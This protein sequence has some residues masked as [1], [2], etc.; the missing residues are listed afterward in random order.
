MAPE[1]GAAPRA[2]CPLPWA[3]LLLL[4]ALLPV[5]SPAGAPA[6]HPLKPR[7]VKLLSTKMGLKVTWDPPK[8]ATSRP[9]EHYNIAYG[10]S[11]KSLKYIKV[12]AE[13]HSFLI[14]DVEPGVVY[15]VLVTAENHNGVSRPVYRAESPPGGEWIQIDGFPIKGPGPFNETV[16]EKEVPNKPLRVRVRSSDDR[17]SIAWKA[18]R[19]SGAKSPRRS[20]GFLLGYGESGR[21]MNYVPLTR[22]ER[23]HEIKKLASESVYVVSLQSMNSQGQSQPVYRA[24]LTKRKISEEDELDV[25]E[26]INVRVMS[27]QSVLVAWVDPVLEKQKKVVASRQYTVRYREKGELARWDHKQTSNRRVL[28]ENLI[29]DTMYEFA[30]RISQGERDGKWSTSVFQRTPESAPTTAPENLN[31]WPVSGKPTAVTVAWDALPETEGKV[32]EYILSY[33]PALK[34]FGAKSLTYPG[35]TTSALV[36]G[37]QPGERYL[38]KIRAANRRGLGPHSKAFIVAIPTTSSSESDVQQKTHPEDNW[39]SEKPETSPKAPTS[40]KHTRLPVSPR[41][42]NVK[43]PL[44]DLKNKILANSGVPRK[45]QIHPKKTEGLDLQSTEIT[46]EEERDSLGDPPTLPSETQDQK[47]QQ[48]LPSRSVPSVLAP[49]RTPVRVQTPGLP[50]KEGID[51]G[52]SS[53]ASYPRPG[54]SPSAP[55][56]SVPHIRM[57]GSPRRPSAGPSTNLPPSSTDND[58]VGQ[59]EE[60]P[61]AGSRDPKDAA[62]QRLPPKSTSHAR[63]ALWPSGQAT[64][65]ALRD[66]SPVHHGTKPALPARR[67]PHLGDREDNSG[68][69]VPP[70]RLSPPQGGSSRLPPTEPHRGA[71]LSRGWKDGYGAAA[72]KSN[73]PSQSRSSSSSGL[74]S[75]TQGSEGE[76]ASD[77]D[78]DNDTEDRGRQAEATAP[79]SRARLPAG[80]PVS[81]HFNLFRN[82]PFAAHT[83]Y[84]SRFGS[85]RGPRLHPSSSPPSTVSPRVH[86]RVNS[87]EVAAESEAE[88]EKPLPATVGNDHVSSS[89]RQPASLAVDHLRK[90]PQRGASL[91]Q[92]EPLAENPK[93]ARP[94]AGAHPQGKPLPSK[95]LDV[96]QSTEV[97][98][99]GGYPKAHLA[100][101]R[102]PATR[103]QH[104]PRPGVPKRTAPGQGL[105]AGAAA[106]EG[107]PSPAVSASQ[108]QPR[109]PQSKDVGHPLSKPKPEL[110]Q[111]ARPHPRAQDSASFSD[112]YA[113]RGS[114]SPHAASSRGVLPTS[115]HSQD[116]DPEARSVGKH[117]D[118]AEAEARGAREPAHPART[119]DPTLSL[120]KHRQPEAPAGGAG[121]SHL[122]RPPG[123]L[124][125]PGG[126]RP[127]PLARPRVPGRAGP[128]AAGKSERASQGAPSKKE[129][130][131]AKSQQSVSAEEEGEGTMFFKGGKDGDPLS[132][133]VPKWPSSSPR[134][135]KY[136]DGN[137]AKDKTDPA[138]VLAP[139]RVSPPQEEK[140]APPPPPGSSPRAPLAPP[141]HPHRGPATPS[142]TVG[143]PARVRY[144]T[145]APPVLAST[146]PMLSLRQ[147]MMNSRFRN[148]LSRQPARSPTRQGYNGSPNVEG[149]VLPGSNGKPSGQ[150]IING[151]QGTKW[152]VDLDRGLVLNAE[153][154]YLQDS[155][156]N[157]LR[158]KLGGDG[159]TIVD[160]GGTPVVSPDGLPL[161]GQGRH[162]K[163]LA[164][165]QD[166]PIL[167]L[168]GKP[169]VGLEVV[170]TTTHAPITTTRPT[171][172]TLR[173]TTATTSRMTTTTRPTT[174]IRTTTQTTTTTTT[175]T[176]TPEPTTP[177]PTCPP[178]TLERHDEDGNLITGSSG[179]PECYPEEDDFSGLETDTAMPT[180]EAYV[181]YDEDYEFETSRPPTTTRPS[182]TATVPEVI[183]VEGS[184]SSFPGEEFDLAGKKR[185]VAPYVTYLSKDP[186]AP[187]S[188]TDALDHFQVDSLDEIIPNDMR[189]SDLAPQHPPRNI[190]V[191]AV[192]GCHSFVIVDWD[193]ATPG[194]V[195]TGYLVY[196]ASYEDFIR[197]KWST[198]ASSVTHLP[199]ENLKPNTR[200]YFKVQAK[201][202]HGYGPISPSVSFV[203]E[204]DNP[205]LVVRPPGGEPIW[206]PFT[207]KHDPSYTDCHG[208]QYVK[209]TWY[210]KFVGVVLCNSLRYKI[211]LSDNLKDTFYSIGDSWGR[212]EDHCQFVDSHL[213]GRTGPQSYV[214]ALPTIQG[215]FR[216][217]RQEPVSFGNIGFGTPY[218]YVGWYECGVSIPGKW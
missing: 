204:S 148:P 173:P 216:Q 168:G 25:P 165:A 192:E 5:V 23:T 17:L 71:P 175:T 107:P 212:G 53:L 86:S 211:Y 40:S 33:A 31:V 59:E 65:S 176:T 174:T 125:R 181:I 85:G 208:R 189:K 108:P 78:G 106:P 116:E 205:L 9:V 190:T 162:G 203:T 56:S 141:R 21:K 14:E 124:L 70:S 66:R 6:D 197:N 20:R 194:D 115:P 117:H 132:S 105:G 29:P 3:A 83:R 81:G 118:S 160:L 159:R 144:T 75:R 183:P 135:S 68:A 99:E 113:A 140:R 30:V 150:R 131:T 46:D 161:F 209:R 170:K 147:R 166:K 82:K 97:G 193:K 139:P 79:T 89:S 88:D 133:S 76:D 92:K 169:L 155:Q 122:R 96:Q 93:S 15:F 49:G 213:D 101:A 19:L 214:E 129:P 146:T 63:P 62:S 41:G 7:H 1:A 73:V 8:D 37:L 154:R 36:D 177:T 196:S 50:R 206:I 120:P 164:S 156:G 187:C 134:G 2:R 34:P 218:Y 48:R 58:S 22:D 158:I 210:R 80:S 64:S 91:Q 24:A 11:L 51:R 199:I 215:Y 4:A 57:E 182:T 60:E 188:L 195:V 54:V 84:P 16:T 112:P 102:R 111:A 137:I 152:V 10:K 74:S 98:A 180:E 130:L 123:S 151:P 127:H 121:D 207:F 95:A 114:E 109:G 172:T 186:S 61:A 200:Y 184:I 198:Q 171:T 18:P 100:P 35:E 47:P 44:L 32:K 119:R 126:P 77:G 28:V 87:H 42:R 178:G 12:N 45:P 136:V 38:F 26:D 202:P 39:K 27:S 149:K 217:Y 153:G 157:P 128:Q 55:A 142:P 185:F 143:T 94:V 167:S 201:N 179:L 191:V 52:S 138:L 69:S 163:P 43:N 67:A 110:P 103:S 145:R 90:G 104:H 72:A 13:T